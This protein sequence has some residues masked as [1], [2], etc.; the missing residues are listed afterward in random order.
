VFDISFGEL[1]LICVVALVVLG[2]ERLPTV[3][4]TLGALVARAQ[5]FVA[6]V[7]ADIG[8]QTDLVGLQALRNEVRDTAYAF[9]EQIVTEIEQAQTVAHE[10]RDEVAALAAE[11]VMPVTDMAP[12]AA[13]VQAEAPAAVAPET[14]AVTSPEVPPETST[15]PAPVVVDENQLDLFAEP[16]P[17]VTTRETPQ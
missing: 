15:G 8:Q 11:P 4:K 5:R 16:V 6:G 7:K 12:P 14:P 1:L 2:P 13:V 3:A 10:A 9:K 17:A